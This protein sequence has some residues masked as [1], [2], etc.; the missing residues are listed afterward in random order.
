MKA[1]RG[2]RGADSEDPAQE[3]THSDNDLRNG[4]F[5]GAPSKS[6]AGINLQAFF[7]VELN[8]S[9]SCS[10]DQALF[11]EALVKEGF[12]LNSVVGVWVLL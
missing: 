3:S 11:I 10:S 7:G 12:E 2:G 5:A 8:K 1:L 4:R 6:P 9:V